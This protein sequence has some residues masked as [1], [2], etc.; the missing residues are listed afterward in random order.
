MYTYEDILKFAESQHLTQH[1]FKEVIQLYE[2]EVGE[3]MAQ[4]YA[5][6]QIDYS[7]CCYCE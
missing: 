1:S 2:M 4:A 3:I 6:Q 5:D 7:K